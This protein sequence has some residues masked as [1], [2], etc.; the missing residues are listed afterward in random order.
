MFATKFASDCECDGLVHSNWGLV[1][2]HLEELPELYLQEHEIDFGSG[3]RLALH[4][5]YGRRFSP[6]DLPSP[7]AVSPEYAEHS[8]FLHPRLQFF[9]Q[10]P[11]MSDGWRP[12]DLVHHLVE[13]VFTDWRSHIGHVALSASGRELLIAALLLSFF[14]N[15]MLSWWSRDRYKTLDEKG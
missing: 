6:S 10:G 8:A 9:E 2:A 13:D 14:C 11:S 15:S 12:P 7:G 1:A 5:R 3:P 4:F